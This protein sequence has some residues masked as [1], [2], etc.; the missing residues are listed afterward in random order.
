MNKPVFLEED[1]TIYSFI[2]FW[3]VDWID[4]SDRKSKILRDMLNVNLAIA[5]KIYK[6]T[7]TLNLDEFIQYYRKHKGERELD[8]FTPQDVKNDSKSL[9]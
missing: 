3:F 8:I 4:T 6:L 1:I 5:T 2:P 7:S 9:Y